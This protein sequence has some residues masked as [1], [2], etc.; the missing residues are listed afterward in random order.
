MKVLPLVAC[1]ASLLTSSLCFA[2]QTTSIDAISR[3]FRTHGER[4]E[5]LV[6]AHRADWRVGPENSLTA[7]RSAIAKHI[8]IVEID[9]QRTSDG[10]LVLMHDTTVDRTTNGTGAVASKTLAALRTLKLKKGLGGAQAPLTEESIPTLAEVLAVARGKIMVQLDKSWDYR[11]QAFQMVKDAGLLDQVI[12]KSSA[13]P[14]EVNEFMA[15]DPRILYQHIIDDGRTGDFD[16]L[17]RMPA[18][19]ELIYD[20]L[21]DAQI[22]PAFV[23]RVR[24]KS[25]I[26]VNTMWRGL[27]AGYTDEA[28]LIDPAAGWDAVIERHHASVI[29]TDNPVMLM[30]WLQKCR[31]PDWRTV[32]ECEVPR[33]TNFH[34]VIIQAED[35][36]TDG[37]DVGY[38]DTDDGNNGGGVYRTYEGV[39]VCNQEGS[40][41]M[42]YIRGGEWVKYRFEVRQSGFYKVSART[43]SPYSPAGLFSV[44][45]DGDGSPATAAALTTTSHTAF[46]MQT[47]DQSRYFRRGEHELMFRVDPVAYQNFNVDYFELEMR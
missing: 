18:A 26:F 42:C 4:A 45:F 34:R 17:T 15:R 2:T 28:S 5:I 36:V 16:Q 1:A 30:E 35:Y 33:E 9:L 46:E 27:A 11:D 13:S 43:S 8:P 31:R 47:L 44:E 37:K 24:A 7:I 40:I 19:F 14:A 3:S 21:T 22:Q 29:Q 38:H 6:A 32:L 41:V 39:D 10:E 12:F 25:R 23:D 20:R